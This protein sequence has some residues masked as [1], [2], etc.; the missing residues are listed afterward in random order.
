[1]KI[2]IVEDEQHLADGLRFNLEAEGYEAVIA[3]DGDTALAYLSTTKFDAV[4]SFV[5]NQRLTRLYCRPLAQWLKLLTELGFKVQTLPMHHG[6]PFAN[7]L[8]VARP[9]SSLPAMP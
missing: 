6:T 7:V 4:V 8:L 5:R 3:G 1:M 9:T 2:L